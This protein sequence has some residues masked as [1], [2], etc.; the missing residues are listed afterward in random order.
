MTLNYDDKSDT[1]HIELRPQ[2]EV[3]TVEV[4]DGLRAGTD[5]KGEVVGLHLERASARVDLSRIEITLP[6]PRSGAGKAKDS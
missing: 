6:V 1:L 5:G 3:E 2:A 4:G